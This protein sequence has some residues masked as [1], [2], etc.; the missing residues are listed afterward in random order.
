MELTECSRDLLLRGRANSLILEN[1]GTIT[2]VD[3]FHALE[4]GISRTT[5]QQADHEALIIQAAS[6]LRGL[7]AQHRTA[8]ATGRPRNGLALSAHAFATGRLQLPA[9]SD[10]FRLCR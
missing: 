2:G 5:T 6:P 7:F 3:E 8:S 10:V 1:C 4:P 9:P